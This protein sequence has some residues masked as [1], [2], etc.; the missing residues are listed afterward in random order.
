[1][2]IQNIKRLET[3]VQEKCKRQDWEGNDQ[4]FN[5]IQVLFI[6]VTI[7]FSYGLIYLYSFF[8]RERERGPRDWG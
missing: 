2:C 4:S 3:S 1:M 6:S 5:I 7:Y 8:L